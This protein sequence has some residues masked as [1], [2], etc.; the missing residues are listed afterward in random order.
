MTLRKALLLFFLLIALIVIGVFAV[1]R[2]SYSGAIF[3]VSLADSEDKVVALTYDDGPNPPHTQALL[4]LLAARDVKATFFVKGRNVAA[5]PDELLAIAEAGHELG[6]HSYDHKPLVAFGENA[7]LE[8]L[9]R[10]AE[11]IERVVGYKPVLFRPPY[12]AQGVGLQRALSRL[13]LK[14]IVMSANGLDWELSDARSIADALLADVR[15]GGILLL[16]DGHGDVDDPLAQ[17]SRAASVEATAIVIDTLRS[18]GYRFVTVTD[19]L[20]LAKKE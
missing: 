14:S 5:F 10:A 16:H 19:L 6:N 18:Q 2:Y 4:L 3:E 12:G 1:A 8:E 13:Q 17:N 9:Q 11:V 20:A 7:I 15:P